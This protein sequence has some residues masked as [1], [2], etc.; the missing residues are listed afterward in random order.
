MSNLKIISKLKW[1]IFKKKREKNAKDLKNASK[2]ANLKKIKKG[3]KNID[4]KKI[5]K[6]TK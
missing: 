6:K 3:M 4:L 5:G 2:L 1:K